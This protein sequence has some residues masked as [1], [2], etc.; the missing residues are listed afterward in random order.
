WTGRLPRPASTRS[1]PGR[2]T[3]PGGSSRR[4]TTPRSPTSAPIGRATGRSRGA[5]A[6]A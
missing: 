4:W 6:S 2:S 5:S 3:P 1:R